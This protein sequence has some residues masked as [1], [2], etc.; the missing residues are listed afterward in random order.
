MRAIRALGTL[1]FLT[2]LAGCAG[3]SS[4]S[5]SPSPSATPAAATAS[6]SSTPS[7]AP[8]PSSD[9]L[10]CTADAAWDG[11]PDAIAGFG[12]AWSAQAAGESLADDLARAMSEGASFVDPNM[13]EAV[14]GRDA[15]GAH[16]VAEAEGRSGT[17]AEYQP[18][19]WIASDTH[20]GYAQLRWRLC[21]GDGRLLQVGDDFLEL[22]ADGRIVRATRFFA[23]EGPEPARPVCQPPN[24]AW[25]GIPDIA[26]KW[27]ATAWSDPDTR[28]TLLREV[29]TEDGWYIDPSDA[30]PVVGYDPLFWRVTEMLWEGAFFE[31][32][33]WTPGDAHHDAMRLRWRL[34][35]AGIPGV[36][37]VDYVR[38]AEDGR[39]ASVVGFFPW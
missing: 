1:L 20:H 5:P 25:E 24:G 19:E 23:T 36:E 29:F 13:D 9:P 15:I 27:A 16:I 10:A 33:A 11:I 2:V 3:G 35:D 28:A 22:D 6:T 31:G 18:R 21:T 30:E 8:S 17:D 12:A 32:T 4:A 34:C 39:F 7:P 14:V 38:L 37:G 26:R